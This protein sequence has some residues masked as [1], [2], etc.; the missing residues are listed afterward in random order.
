MYVLRGSSPKE[1]EG[2]SAL[3]CLS[4]TALSLLGVLPDALFDDEQASK[5]AHR[6]KCSGGGDHLCLCSPRVKTA[7]QNVPACLARPSELRRSLLAG[8]LNKEAPH[9]F[10]APSFSTLIFLPLRPFSLH[11]LL[12]FR[13]HA[14]SLVLIVTAWYS[15]K[16]QGRHQH[17]A[18][19]TVTQHST[20]RRSALRQSKR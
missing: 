8:G 11:T 14:R 12:L 9:Q 5:R 3:A 20:A 10:F 19:S 17:L 15:H 1:R 18:R 7:A 13:T 6:M 2:E 4:F 16:D